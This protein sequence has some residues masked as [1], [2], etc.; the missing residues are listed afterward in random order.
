MGLLVSSR[1]RTIHAPALVWDVEYWAVGS[2][3]VSGTE[4]R[5][6]AAGM[7]EF[8]VECRQLPPSS[9]VVLQRLCLNQS[10]VYFACTMRR[11]CFRI[12]LVLS[13]CP[14]SIRCDMYTPRVCGQFSQAPLSKGPKS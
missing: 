2:K 9:F 11:R 10:R 1:H 14:H 7:S 4:C 6:Y 8:P 3:T 5:T 13:N 12:G